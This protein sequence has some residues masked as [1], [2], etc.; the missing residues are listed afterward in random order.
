MTKYLLLAKDARK[1]LKIKEN[2]IFA[3][4]KDSNNHIIDFYFEKNQ[5][6][7]HIYFFIKKEKHDASIIRND[8]FDPS[9]FFAK[10]KKYTF[11]D[12]RLKELFDTFSENGLPE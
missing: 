12:N 1:L 8:M 9:L 5:L 7:K 11:I 3:T 10:I 4:A 6:V 2:K